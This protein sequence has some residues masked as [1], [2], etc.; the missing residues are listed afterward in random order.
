MRGFAT[1]VGSK[2][3]I[4]AGPPITCDISEDGADLS[5][6]ACSSSFGPAGNGGF[7]FCV[8]IA[9]F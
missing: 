4:G 9:S 2:A 1:G 3:D 8:L 5:I 7:S 6:P